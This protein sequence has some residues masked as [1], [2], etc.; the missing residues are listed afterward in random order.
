MK[1]IT[2]LGA[3]VVLAGL[4]GCGGEGE[5]EKPLASQQ[6]TDA[7]AVKLITLDP[8][9]FHAALVQKTMYP[10]IDPVVHV[11]AP[12]GPEVAA[13]LALIDQ[14]NTRPE[15]PST[16]KQV[17]YKGTDYRNKM[18]SEKKG[19][20]VVLS[21]NNRHKTEFIQESVS[22]GL[23][24][25]ADKPMA[26]NNGD[27]LLLTRS[28]QEAEAKKVL[29]YDIMTE[30]SE[31]TNILQKEFAAVP[32]LFGE[33]TKGTPENPAITLESVHYYYKFVSGKALTR[34][35]WFFDPMQQGE[36]VADVGTH[37]VDLVHW[38]FFPEQALNYNSDIVMGKSKIWFTPMTLSQFSAV[39][40]KDSFP[41]F[42]KKYV[43]KD[44]VLQTHSNGEVNYSVKGTHV[45]VIARWDYQA[46]EGGDTHYAIAKGSKAHLIIRQGKDEKYMPT[47][48]IMPV[49]GE[50]AFDSAVSAAVNKIAATYPGISAVKY[51][52]GYEI[53][54]PG[55]YKVGHEAHFGQ[56]MERYLS[57]LKEGK[58]PAWEVPN[59]LTKYYIT[60]KSAE[61]AE[62]G[63]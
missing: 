21:G 55:S 1:L 13:H 19:N 23:N 50:K 61:T 15:N 5:K 10:G 53:K 25:L 57:Y 54:I 47:L 46:K 16:W 32:E 24:V 26:I 18:L 41:E 34:P 22:A 37:L 12:E 52:D 42:L 40:K 36:A 28:F 20:L 14:Y 6:K 45:R 56:V 59:M 35:V 17:V 63:K 2:Y 39:T 60:T 38:E 8:G 33:L 62:V 51:K 49:K 29:L 48:Y 30:R 31:I 58:L 27:F 44:T 3:M 4:A 7:A 43:V 11:Y 9:H